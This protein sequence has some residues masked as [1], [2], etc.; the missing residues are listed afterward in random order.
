MPDAY[1][2]NTDILHKNA[3]HILQETFKEGFQ[4]LHEPQ[5][6]IEQ[7]PQSELFIS[8]EIY[9]SSKHIF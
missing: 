8:I 7:T 9:S 6:I 5:D 2:A 3:C 1:I 4:I